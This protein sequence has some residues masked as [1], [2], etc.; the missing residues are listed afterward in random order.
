M[1]RRKCF[2][3]E[4]PG[5]ADLTGRLTSARYLPCGCSWAIAENIAYGGGRLGSPREIVE[6][7]MHSPDHRTN[8]LNPDYRD[9]GIGA[10]DGTPTGGRGADGATYTTDFGYRR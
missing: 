3:H 6:A 9:I 1:V 4:C 2:S 7:W 5:E 8:M 10:D